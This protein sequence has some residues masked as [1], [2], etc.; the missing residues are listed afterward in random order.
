MEA[1]KEKEMKKILIGYN[2]QAG[3][4]AKMEYVNNC[5]ALNKLVKILQEDVFLQPL[6]T[7]EL[8]LISKDAHKFVKDAKINIALNTEFPNAP[9]EFRLKS[10]GVTYESL[11][12]H[13]KTV[14]GVKYEY[15]VAGG[16]IITVEPEIQRLLDTGKI[17]TSNLKQN[18]AVKELTIIKEQM[19]K[20]VDSGA[21]ATLSARGGA[22]KT[23]FNNLLEI[24][25][26][27][28]PSIELNAERIKQI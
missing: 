9:I 28:P 20:L 11:N 14:S 5:D 22:I 16:E 18:E 17:Y 6:S 27:T 4:I 26:T 12:P 2:Q 23:L 7:A 13:L 25:F 21:I 15:A 1:I 24:R 3:Q 19:T 10:Q 8:E